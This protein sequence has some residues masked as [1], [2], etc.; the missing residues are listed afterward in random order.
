[1][2]GHGSRSRQRRAQAAGADRPDRG[3]LD[4]LAI[5]RLQ[6]RR[7]LELEEALEDM[8]TVLGDGTTKAGGG[9][10]GGGADVVAGSGAGFGRGCGPSA[11]GT[12]A[13]IA[14]SPRSNAAARL[15]MAVP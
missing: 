15:D 11:P 7:T 4:R 10:G 8:R 9:G 6:G 2:R 3:D 12:T 13:H 1:V 14:V 5:G